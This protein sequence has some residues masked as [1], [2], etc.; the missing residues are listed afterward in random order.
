MPNYPLFITTLM[1]GGL[2][3]GAFHAAGMLNA[4]VSGGSKAA[5]ATSYFFLGGQTG[6]ALGPIIAGIVVGQLGLMGM[7]LIALL[8]LPA[9]AL[10]FLYM[11]D[12][13]PAAPRV[14]TQ[15][16]SDARASRLHGA[17]A[18]TITAFVLFIVFRSGTSQG[19]ATLL[20]AYFASLGYTAA[21]FGLMLGIF[22]FAGALGTLAGGYLGD[23]FNRRTIMITA[24]FLSA[25]FAYLM[26][27]TTGPAFIV[28]AILAGMFL[29][30]PH[31]ILLVL[32]Q[33]L[34][35][36]NRGLV[37]G[38]V[39]GFIFASGSVMAWLEAIVATN[40]GLAPVLSVVA[41]FPL[42]AGLAGFWLPATPTR[43]P[44]T[45]TSTPAATAAD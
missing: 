35:P 8:A 16:A 15:V 41:F 30:M 7:P 23:R 18:L 3:S 37:G 13:L 24:S 33:E 38:L 12:A 26:L 1:I 4:S 29:S 36:N 27:H 34:A 44:V 25:P 14:A 31:S 28:T 43:R 9:I 22:N 2:G 20:P 5:T 17:A 40:V 42:L 45:V 32:A 11:N 19:F 6:L 10:M 21:E 39:L